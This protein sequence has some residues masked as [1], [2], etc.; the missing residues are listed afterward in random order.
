MDHR[1][2]NE[3][4]LK[5]GQVWLP[6]NE[7]RRFTVERHKPRAPYI[8][9]HMLRRTDPAFCDPFADLEIVRPEAI[10]LMNHKANAVAN[11][12]NQGFGFP[13]KGL[14]NRPLAT[15]RNVSA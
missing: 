7:K 11:L 14:P 1:F 13:E 12:I 8:H 5:R 6:L 15:S 10:I 4:A 2:E 3:I 9:L